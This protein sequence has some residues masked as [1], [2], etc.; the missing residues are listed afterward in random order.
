MLD[1]ADSFER[2]VLHTAAERGHLE[3]VKLI[4]QVQEAAERQKREELAKE[5]E[6]SFL[7][8]DFWVIVGSR[9]QLKGEEGACRESV[10]TSSSGSW[11]MHAVSKPP[12]RASVTLA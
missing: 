9:G 2:T 4:L 6:V 7:V 12:L 5:L 10:S 11:E 1:V 8:P 3:L